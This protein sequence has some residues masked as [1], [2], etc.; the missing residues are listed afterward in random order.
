MPYTQRARQV[1]AAA[2]QAAI[3]IVLHRSISAADALSLAELGTL[4]EVFT[5][6]QDRLRLIRGDR[7]VERDREF[8]TQLA[9]KELLWEARGVS[10]R[11]RKRLIKRALNKRRQQLSLE[12]EQQHRTAQLDGFIHSLA[13]QGPEFRAF[14]RR[15]QRLLAEQEGLLR[16]K[17]P[18]DALPSALR[19]LYSIY[20]RHLGRALELHEATHLG[21]T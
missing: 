14:L 2:I 15:C 20:E 4:D 10:V 8:Q 17:V 16:T 19:A 13:Q 11:D 3:R 9:V 12:R 6:L 5:R 1:L 18:A 21:P 7:R